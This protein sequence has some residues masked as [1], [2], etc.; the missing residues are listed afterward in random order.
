MSFLNLHWMPSSLYLD[1]ADQFNDAVG[2]HTSLTKLRRF[3]YRNCHSLR[4]LPTTIRSLTCSLTSL[5]SLYKVRPFPS[6]NEEINTPYLNK[7]RTGAECSLEEVRDVE[8]IIRAVD[9]TFITLRFEVEETITQPLRYLI[10][11]TAQHVLAQVWAPM[12]YG[13]QCVLT[14]S[15]QSFVLGRR[16]NELFQCRVAPLTFMFSLDEESDADPGFPGQFFPLKL[17]LETPNVQFYYRKEYPMLNHAPYYYVRGTLALPVFEA[18]QRSRLGVL[19]L[20]MSPQKFFC[21]P[22]IIQVRRAPEGCSPEE[23]TYVENVNPSMDEKHDLRLQCMQIRQPAGS[24]SGTETLPDGGEMIRV[25]LFEQQAMM[26]CDAI[27][28]GD[29]VGG[30]GQSIA[31]ITLSMVKNKRKMSERKCRTDKSIDLP[32]LQQLVGMKRKDAAKMLNVSVSTFKRYCRQ[33]GISQWPSH[34]IN[35]DKHSLYMLKPVTESVQ[36]AE[37][38]HSLTSLGPELIPGAIDS[39]SWPPSLNGSH[40]RYLPGS[41]LP[42]LQAEKNESFTCKTAAN[43]GRA[44]REDGMLGGRAS[45]QKKLIHKHIMLS[46]PEFGK[47]SNRSKMENGSKE[48]STWTPTSHDLCHEPQRPLGGSLIENSGSSKD[49]R[50]FFPSA[51]A[52]FLEGRV[53]ESSWTDPPCSDP[54]PKQAAAT[55]PQPMPAKQDMRIVTFKATYRVDTLKFRLSSTSGIDEL[56][57]EVTKRLPLEAGTFNIKYLDDD[58]EWILIA[59]DADLQ[60]CMNMSSSL[61]N[62][63]I[64][65]LVHDKIA[66][67][68]NSSKSCRGQ[69]RKRL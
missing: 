51:A 2:L 69:K 30:E 11:S 6:E 8:T 56:K 25:D 21:A 20:I 38:S 1:D 59:C 63:I 5:K 50:N 33:N 17:P 13:G 53:S 32:V 61:G 29:N 35:K 39:V 64:R 4:R 41:K 58:R 60:D 62:N 54:A 15:G 3:R 27:N 49:L 44:E 31:A 12:K 14:T 57:E 23:A 68:R 46:P 66:N 10:T 26:E 55:L 43:D 45:I 36:G 24:Q 65:L 22:D 37:G 40:Q 47:D 16:S 42:E 34:K 18:A 28:N 19:E 52:A 9:E 7:F 67:S 48:E